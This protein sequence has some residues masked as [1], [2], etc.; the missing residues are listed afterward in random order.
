[1]QKMNRLTSSTNLFPDLIS[2]AEAS[3]LRH[4]SRPAIANL[5][6]QG[7]LKTY[8]VAGL[9]VLSKTEVLN[10]EAKPVGRPRNN[11]RRES[12]SPGLTLGEE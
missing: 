7:K 12:F 1:M 3:R 8:V 9:R 5:I 4:C 11:K 10:Y 6:K 2:Q